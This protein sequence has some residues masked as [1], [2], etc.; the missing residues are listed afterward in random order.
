MRQESSTEETVDTANEENVK[1][2]EKDRDLQIKR[3]EAENKKLAKTTSI[4]AYIVIGS[5]TLCCCCLA[6]LGIYFLADARKKERELQERLEM[7]KM[8]NKFGSEIGALP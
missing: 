7:N 5:S 2:L 1:R 8:F 4:I 3:L 6:G